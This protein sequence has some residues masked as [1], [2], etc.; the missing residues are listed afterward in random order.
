MNPDR[1]L[2][3]AIDIG[4]AR[5]S[6]GLTTLRG[7]LIDRTQVPVDHG[8]GDEELFDS[9]VEIVDAMLV[10]ADEHHHL[11]PLAVGVACA[12]PIVGDVESVSPTAVGAWRGFPLRERLEQAVSLP[13]YGADDAV[14]L[15]MAEGW[16]GAAQGRANFLTVVVSSSISGAV[17]LDGQVLEGATGAAGRIGHVVVEPNGRRC[18]CG[19]RGCL[20]AEASGRA[21]EAITG[22][23]PTEPSYE[24][25]Q[26]TGELVGRAV[27]SSCNLLDLDLAV[28]GGSVALGFG[29]T[30]FNAAQAALDRHSRSE[31][32][33]GAR[34]TPAR[35]GDRGPLVG[36]GA[37]GLRGFRRHGT[38]SLPPWRPRERGDRAGVRLPGE[39]AAVGDPDGHDPHD[40]GARADPVDPWT[41]GDRFGDAT[42]GGSRRD[43]RSVRHG[44]ETPS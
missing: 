22:R 32:T 4:G 36:A 7:D 44:E 10:R 17:V 1:D 21:I 16:L 11:V 40:P 3:V 29:A 35:L 2:I 43:A 6:A 31:H 9:L 33:R 14:A 8:L 24:I 12:G 37:I 18:S 41:H 19:A 42:P 28:M 27:A 23:S 26:R 38:R 15:A 34:I 13:V 20:D 39:G 5:L 25:M 30:F